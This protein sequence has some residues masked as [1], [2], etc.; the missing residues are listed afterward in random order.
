MSLIKNILK[1]IVFGYRYNSETL[2]KYY[3]KK[4][5]SIGEGTTFFFPR[6]VCLDLTRPYMISIGNNVQIT[7]NVTILTHGYDWS[8]LKH[9]F[10]DILGSAGNV[11]IGDNVFIGFNTTILKGVKIGNNVIIGANTLVNKDIPDNSVAVGTPCKVIMNIDEYYKKRLDEQIKEASEQCLAYKNKYGTW[12]NEDELNEFYF[13]F[14]P[15]EEKS[16]NDKI[17]DEKMKLVNSYNKS[18]EKFLKTPAKFNGYKEFLEY[19]D[20]KMEDNV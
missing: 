7:R 3:R 1:K 15:R 16:F 8:V 5:V 12:P 10:G 17:F 18:K 19:L 11:S 14:K 9:E 6:E 2:V 13:L 20:K 4:G